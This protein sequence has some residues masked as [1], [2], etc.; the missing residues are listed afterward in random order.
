MKDAVCM[1]DMFCMDMKEGT[2]LVRFLDGE[3][4]RYAKVVEGKAECL[5]EKFVPT[6]EKLPL[7]GLKI[8][9]PVEVREVWCVGLN[10][11]AHAGEMGAKL[12][13]TPCFFMKSLNTLAA[14]E[15]PVDYPSW[16]GRIDYEGELAVVIGKECKNVDEKEALECVWGYSCY[17]D[18]TARDLQSKDVQWGR[19]KSFD[20]FGPMGPFLLVAK[21]MPEGAGLRTRLNGKTVQQ[22]PFSD[23]IFPVA[24]IVSELSRFITLN[25]GVVIA[26]GTPSGVG[27]VKPGDVV[28]VEIDG[29]GVLRNTFGQ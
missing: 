1:K 3:K 4:K 5:D 16:A 25:A 21:S 12:P 10:Y 28:E 22:S 6:G 26:T 24:R 27:P 14:H 19:A 9:P 7:D 18:V 8:L 11:R 20:T 13:E 23:L 17:N 29:I 2:L 15:D